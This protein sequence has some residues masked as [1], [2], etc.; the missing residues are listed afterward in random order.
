MRTSDRVSLKTI[1]G[2]LSVLAIVAALP[3][4]AAQALPASLSLDAKPV[5]TAAA[6]P[7]D[8]AAPTLPSAAPSG[9]VAAGTPVMAPG[10]VI[11]AAPSS[12]NDGSTHR[13]QRGLQ[14]YNAGDGRLAVENWR[15]AAEDGHLPAMWNLSILYRR[16]ELVETDIPESI[17]YLRRVAARHDPNR[18]PG[19]EAAMTVAALV[20]LADIY[21]IGEE[22]AGIEPSPASAA[23]MYQIAATLYG[24]ARAQHRL[25]MMYL[26]GEGVT[27][28]VG[29]AVRWLA[30]SAKKRYVPSFA[31][32]GDFYWEN[33]GEGNNKIRGLMWL[34]LAKEN[35]KHEDLRASV[36]VR[37]NAAM[38]EANEDERK[39]ATAL[40]ESWNG[41][42]R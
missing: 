22:A 26:A 15:L 41:T 11:D 5:V 33:R 32:L 7:S 2:S 34:S 36:T 37:Y 35:A 29:R 3:A 8:T 23:R 16:G 24:D 42:I 14:A 13:F 21:R 25:G 31:A 40:I 19:A 12:E 17:H 4:I 20:E 39:E 9:G 6:A 18:R 28:H 10:S 1:V 27:Q 30:L 38:V